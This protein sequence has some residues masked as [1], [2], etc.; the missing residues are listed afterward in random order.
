MEWKIAFSGTAEE[1]E[2]ERERTLCRA[3]PS[4]R[5]TARCEM[6]RGHDGDRPY[7]GGSPEAAE[8]LAT[9]HAGRTRGGYWK[10]WL[11]E[12]EKT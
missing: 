10:F 5:S 9:F 11:A 3:Q 12:E 4:P 2:A 6:N 8:F 1:W 7:E